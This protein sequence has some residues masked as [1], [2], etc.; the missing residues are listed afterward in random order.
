MKRTHI[1]EFVASHGQTK[2][3]AALGMTQGALSKALRLGRDIFVIE[4]KDGTFTGEEIR[5]FPS[6][7]PKY[8]A[9]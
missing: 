2:T 1:K 7:S 4:H 6:Q 9:A 5:R 3:A 8:Q